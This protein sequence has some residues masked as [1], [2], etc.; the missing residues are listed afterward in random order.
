MGNRVREYRQARCWRQRDLA[1]QVEVLSRR[2]LN[3][4]LSV[5]ERTV[6]RWERGDTPSL[7]A[8]RVLSA[9]F[10]ASP[11]ELGFHRPP[12]APRRDVDDVPGGVDAVELV[13]RLTRS[14]ASDGTMALLARRVDRLCRD[15]PTR[16]AD[17]LLVEARDWLAR[18]LTLTDQRLSLTQHR[19]ALVQAG[20][21]SALVACLTYDL[22]D[23]SGAETWREA[24]AQ[25][26]HEADHSELVAWSFEIAAWM[27]LTSGRPGHA[28]ACA[29]AGERINHT[30]CVGA[31][32]AAQ[33]ARAL[34]LT[35]DRA[36]A[37]TAMARGRAILAQLPAP[38]DPDHHFVIDPAKADFYAVDVYRLLDV[39]E[40][41]TDYATRVLD[42]CGPGGGVIRS[43]MRRSEALL[44]LGVVAARDGD[45]D[46]AVHRGTTAL[47]DPRQCLPSL[48]TVAADLH[49]AL[50][51]HTH[52][53]VTAPWRDA[54]AQVRDTRALDP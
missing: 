34:A 17:D 7:P 33:S 2:V 9:L 32:L 40:A 15:Y 18:T 23:A 21:L 1:D 16:R 44:T 13:A 31:Q 36:G 49:T 6:S 5:T 29:A 38:V 47:G 53:P 3:E 52:E 10:E 20:W 25:L 46:T 27:A 51:P 24:T 43:P 28:A 11:E 41:A 30:S 14:D 4:T 50:Q 26:G 8:Q 19:E 22:G 48:L 42:H 37:E 39:R 35:G 12:P 45:L 54:L